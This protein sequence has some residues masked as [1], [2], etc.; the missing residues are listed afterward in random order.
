MYW[1]KPSGGNAGDWPVAERSERR[2][3]KLVADGGEPSVRGVDT[4]ARAT[5]R[6][7]STTLFQGGKLVLIEHA[8]SEYR[9]H[10][11]SRGKLILTR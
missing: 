6:I 4:A 8:G 10:I 11:T 7:A 5:P 9:L 2:P 3:V 1:G